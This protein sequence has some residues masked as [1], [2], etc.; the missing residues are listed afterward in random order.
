MAEPVYL[1]ERRA[2][3]ERDLARDLACALEAEADALGEAMARAR[4][5]LAL[6]PPSHWTEV[7]DRWLADALAAT[8][9]PGPDDPP[10]DPQE[11]S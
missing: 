6:A 1:P 5:A 4:I 7:A 2:V 3:L 10:D 11:G 8:R 9:G